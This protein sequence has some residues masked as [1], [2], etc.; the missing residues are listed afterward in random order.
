MPFD[1]NNEGDNP[2]FVGHR[3]QDN[4]SQGTGLN[5]MVK[6]PAN[7]MARLLRSHFPQAST[8]QLD[9]IKK[10]L[11]G[12]GTLGLIGKP[13]FQDRFLEVGNA[14]IKSQ[15]IVDMFIKERDNDKG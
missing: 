11:E 10:Q 1:L 6:T 7:I 3:E 8:H 15:I 2:F 12:E 13:E 4:Y 5:K 14:V 9:R